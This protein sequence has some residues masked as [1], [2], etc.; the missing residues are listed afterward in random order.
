[1]STLHK[2]IAVKRERE[3]EVTKKEKEEKKRLGC[4]L[5][6]T[7]YMSDLFQMSDLKKNNCLFTLQVY[8]VK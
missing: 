4:I 1:M 2:Y 8:D 5:L 6:N 3:R 7:V